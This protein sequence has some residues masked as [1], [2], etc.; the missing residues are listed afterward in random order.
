MPLA[1]V[2]H[3]IPYHIISYHTITVCMY[4]CMS[5]HTYHIYMYRVDSLLTT[6]IYFYIYIY[7]EHKYSTCDIGWDKISKKRYRWPGYIR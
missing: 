1:Y 6:C 5:L 2:Y 3:I 7:I 4:V